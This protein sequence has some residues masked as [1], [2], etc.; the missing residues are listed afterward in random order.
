MDGLTLGADFRT[1]KISILDILYSGFLLALRFLMKYAKRP[2]IRSSLKK[3]MDEIKAI[4]FD[5]DGVLIDSVKANAIFFE[6]LFKALGIKYTQKEYLKFHHKTMWDV[7]KHFSGVQSKAKIS[8]MFE[9]AKKFPNTHDYIKVPK[10]AVKIL[11]TL[12]KKY[13]IGVV[14]ARVKIGVDPVLK[15]FGYDKKIISTRVAF[16]DYKNPKPHPEPLL[17]AMKRMKLK[18]RE[19]IYVGD[20]ESDIL[21]AQAAGTKSILYKNSYSRVG[22]SKPDYI[23]KSFKELLAIFS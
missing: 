20:M 8:E 9:F 21:C 10:D 18:P 12:S 5:I 3:Y 23:V 15:R 14:T 1:V 7:I 22:K 6:R 13:K 4:I 16:E 19:V 11:S 17:V 2:K